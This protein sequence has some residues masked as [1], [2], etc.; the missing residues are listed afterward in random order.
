MSRQDARIRELV[1][2]LLVQGTPV[3]FLPRGPSMNPLMRDGDVVCVRPT[4]PAVLRAGYIVLCRQHNRLTLHRLIRHDAAGERCWIVADAAIRGIDC[5]PE[6]DV[7]GLAET[8]RHGHH[9]RRLDTRYA[10]WKGLARYYARP[11]RRMLICA[12][13]CWKRKT[14]AP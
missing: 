2:A 8:V 9:Q 5:I 13:S 10:R 7:I 11:L 4:H 12:Y 3:H 1:Y 6:A 14:I